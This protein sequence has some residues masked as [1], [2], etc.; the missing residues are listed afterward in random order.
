MGHSKG[1][2]FGLVVGGVFSA[3]ALIF[4]LRHK[5]HIPF[6]VCV[7]VGPTLLVLGL[8]APVLLGPVEKVWMAVAGVL[9]WI[10]ARILLSIV[11]VVLVAPVALVLRLLGR[12]PL[13]R[14]R[15]PK[16]PSYWIEHPASDPERYKRPY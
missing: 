11:F 13:A 5:H 1:R 6:W 14:R 8:I 9:G 15:D 2:K 3:F 4:F 12:D 7:T 16:A 10:N